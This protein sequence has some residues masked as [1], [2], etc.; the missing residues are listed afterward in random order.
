MKSELRPAYKVVGEEFFRVGYLRNLPKEGAFFEICGS[1]WINELG[2]FQN[3]IFADCKHYVLQFYD[4]TVEIIA[5]NLIF[6][7]TDE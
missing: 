3:R 5:S 2:E 7:Q 6:K 1:P 4:E